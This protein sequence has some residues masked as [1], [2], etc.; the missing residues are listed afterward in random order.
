MNLTQILIN[1]LVRASE[2]G[3]IAMGVTLVFSLLR[4]ANFAHGE[5]ALIGAYLAYAL[6][7]AGLDLWLAIP[8]SAVAT[9]F[10]AVAI[11]KALFARVRTAPGLVLLVASMGLSLFLK[12]I[13]GAI[14]GT[15]SYSFEGSLARSFS[16]AGGFITS[17]QVTILVVSVI[18]MLCFHLL[19]SHTRLGRAMRALADDS[20]LARARGIRV[21]AIISRV[22]FIVGS[23]AALGGAL[24]GLETVISLELGYSVIL[25]AFAAAVLGG[26]GSV[27]GAMLGALI[28]GLAEN[29]VLAIDWSFLPATSGP[30]YIDTGYK[31]A[32]AFLV[33]VAV[34]ILRPRGLFQG[35]SGD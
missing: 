7:A 34:L 30:L 32:V 31:L 10:I 6:S 2:L 26:I 5:L 23:Y 33:M 24:I 19:L 20:E 16:F 29:I 4:F 28:I 35:T 15:K 9:G 17:T 22:W 25:P 11:D 18:A 12:N 1:S 13:V 21:E 3:L 14:W 27:H 8:L